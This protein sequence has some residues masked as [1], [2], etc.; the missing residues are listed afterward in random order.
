MRPRDSTASCAAPAR[1]SKARAAPSLHILGGLP[2]APL[3]LAAVL[4]PGR[5]S[6]RVRPDFSTALRLVPPPPRRDAG[7]RAELC[8]DSCRRRRA[9]TQ[10]RGQSSAPTRAAAAAPRRRTE[11]AELCSRRRHRIDGAPGR[12]CLSRLRR[13]DSRVSWRVATSAVAPWISPSQLVICRALVIVAE[14]AIS[15]TAGGERMQ[16]SSQTVPRCGSFM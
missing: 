1:S 6:Q 8:S 2:A 7:P 9:E 5:E 3:V 12:A 4:V 10:D 16:H 11:G 15:C 14:R 13:G